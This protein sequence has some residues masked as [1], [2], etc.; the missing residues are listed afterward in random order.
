MLNVFSSYN[1]PAGKSILKWYIWSIVGILHQQQRPVW[2]HQTGFGPVRSQLTCSQTQLPSLTDFSKHY[3]RFVVATQERSNI[4]VSLLFTPYLKAES[5]CTAEIIFFISVKL[6]FGLYCLM[7]K[8]PWRFPC[9]AFAVDVVM[10]VCL[11]INSGI[12]L[13]SAATCI[14]VHACFHPPHNSDFLS[15]RLLADIQ[16]LLDL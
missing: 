11:M 2:G 3:K 1:N 4:G 16:F 8:G 7:H 9:I 10:H 12:V 14:D 13:Q 5:E 6:F 15:V